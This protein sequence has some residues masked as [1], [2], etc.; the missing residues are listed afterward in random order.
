MRKTARAAS[1]PGDPAE[2]V[3][4]DPGRLADEEVLT[5]GPKY[6]AAPPKTR[7]KWYRCRLSREQ[8]AKLNRRSDFLGFV[9]TLG[10]LAVLAI[11]AGFA[12][13][14]ALNW[15][16]Y[17]TLV[18]VFVNGHFWHFLVNGFSRARA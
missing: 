4:P 11:A 17:V 6:N 10:Y 12:I 1:P 7:V 8:L 14:S 15:P 9:Q 18:L 5:E 16:W 3:G 13:Y 2:I